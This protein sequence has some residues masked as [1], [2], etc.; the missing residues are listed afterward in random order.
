MVWPHGIQ[1]INGLQ[2]LESWTLAQLRLAAGVAGG[3]DATTIYLWRR[4]ERL[5]YRNSRSHDDL[6]RA[7]GQDNG[8]KQ[9]N[10]FIAVVDRRHD[11]SRLDS[12]D[13]ARVRSHRLVVGL[14]VCRR[15]A[16]LQA[17][18]FCIRQLHDVGLWRRNTSAAMATARPDH[19]D[20]RRIAVW[21]VDRRYFRDPAQDDGC[22]RLGGPGTRNAR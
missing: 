20:E 13:R 21:L 8:E 1:G 22:R 14:L 6:G 12:H 17:R 4:R 9:D 3:G 16:R 2:I 19:G 7:G 11:Y 10:A 5:Q 15:S 18:V